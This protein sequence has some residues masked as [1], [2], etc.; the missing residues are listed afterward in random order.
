MKPLLALALMTLAA[1][2]IRAQVVINELMQSNIDCIM[3]D[4]NEFPDSWVELY[5]A[6]TT[7]V[8]LAD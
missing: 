4:I 5:N 2:N 8:D 1:N 6:G 7:A 3:D